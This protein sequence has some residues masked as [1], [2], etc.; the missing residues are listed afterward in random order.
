M[1][2]K[3]SN[4][5]IILLLLIVGCNT[6]RNKGAKEYPTPMEGYSLWGSYANTS[7]WT[8]KNAPTP[9]YPVTYLQI[10]ITDQINQKPIWGNTFREGGVEWFDEKSV[11]ISYTPGNPERNKNYYIIY[12]LEKHEEIVVEKERALK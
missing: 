2:H 8:K 7:I 1:N 10:M 11:K 5:C 3:K 9:K 4:Y 6:I 12:N